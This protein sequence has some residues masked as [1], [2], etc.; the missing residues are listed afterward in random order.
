MKKVSKRTT[1]SIALLSSLALLLMMTVGGTLAY[2]VAQSETLTNTMQ[3]SEVECEVI[4][5]DGSFS[6][7]NAGDIKAYLRAAVV[8]NWAGEE[9]NSANTVYGNAPKASDYTLE[10]ASEW[11]KG[12]DGYYYYPTKVAP[13]EVKAFITSY[14]ISDVAEAPLGYALQVEVLAQ[15]IQALPDEAVEE[16]WPAV[17]VDANGKLESK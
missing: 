5:E 3:S 1:K 11:V 10:I 17:Q 16:A 12:A 6:V 13:S 7:K 15:S 4:K 2:L 9:G 8:V 14:G